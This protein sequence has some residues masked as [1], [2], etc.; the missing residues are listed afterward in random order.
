M[1]KVR[2]AFFLSCLLMAM[3]TSVVQAKTLLVV[4]PFCPDDLKN[5]ATILFELLNKMTIENYS[6]E[7]TKQI[8]SIDS[9]IKLSNEDSLSVIKKTA[10]KRKND[11]ILFFE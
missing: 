4:Y 6:I 9:F 11:Y 5:E 3:A 1:K 2:R 8:G 7:N 10:R